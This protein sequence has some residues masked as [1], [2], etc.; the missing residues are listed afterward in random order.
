MSA[1]LQAATSGSAPLYAGPPLGGNSTQA[2]PSATRLS[3]AS[4][5]TRRVCDPHDSHTPAALAAALR[6]NNQQATSAPA[7]ISLMRAGVAQ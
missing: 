6:S 4:A 5:A 3:G 1:A 7:R 2:A